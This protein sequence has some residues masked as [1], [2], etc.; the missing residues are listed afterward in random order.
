MWEATP[1][2]RQKN[3]CKQK[4]VLFL[5]H[6]KAE[7]KQEQPQGATNEVTIVGIDTKRSEGFRGWGTDASG[8]RRALTVLV[9]GRQGQG[10]LIRWEAEQAVFGSFSRRPRH[11]D[12]HGTT[13]GLKH[14][15]EIRPLYSVCWYGTWAWTP[16]MLCGNPKPMTQS[17][18]QCRQ[19]KVFNQDREVESKAPQPSTYLEKKEEIF[20]WRNM[21]NDCIQT[22]PVNS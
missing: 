6:R 15:W 13:S 14:L 22:I 11:M 18:R 4:L 12:R 5:I 10:A 3:N 8:L 1:S 16:I 19:V 7:A 17:Q 9:L 20:K 2:Q 21:G